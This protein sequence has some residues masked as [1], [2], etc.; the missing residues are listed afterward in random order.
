MKWGPEEAAAFE[1]LKQ[2]LTEE[3]ELFQIDVDAPYTM[4]T[5]ASDFAIGAVLEQQRGDRLV[6]VAFYSRKLSGSQLN[7]TPREKE[8]YAIVCSLRKWAG[9]VGFQPIT[10]M[11]DH[12]SLEEWSNEL[13]DTPS[14]PRGRKA[15]WHETLSQFKLAVVYIPGKDNVV[16]DALSRWA[17]PASSARED[18]S[19]QGSLK[20]RDDV[21]EML[22]TEREE[23]LEE[24][25]PPTPL[26]QERREGGGAQWFQSGYSPEVGL[27]RRT[28]DVKPTLKLA[29]HPAPREHG[30]RVDG[31]QGWLLPGRHH[32]C[33]ASRLKGSAPEHWRAD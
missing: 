10:I 26:N 11:T 6:P 20:A 21:R 9:W 30:H 1:A 24:Q 19:F 25:N 29:T 31:R 5:D 33:Q 23:D 32:S 27:E 28:L 18:V 15:R 16:A 17:Y 14:G 22:K 2:A 3:L 4:R 13:L 8:C 12:R 7:W